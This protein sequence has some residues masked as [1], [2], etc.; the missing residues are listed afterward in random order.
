MEQLDNILVASIL[1]Q[2]QGS[3]IV[4]TGDAGITSKAK[5]QSNQVDSTLSNRVMKCRLARSIRGVRIIS[6]SLEDDD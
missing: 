4:I 1:G 2:I 3:D 6:V 5:Q